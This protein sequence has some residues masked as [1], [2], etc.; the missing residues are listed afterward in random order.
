[1]EEDEWGGVAG[2]AVEGAVD[3]DARRRPFFA[4]TR[5]PE[6]IELRERSGWVPDERVDV[7]A[8]VADMAGRVQHSL[9]LAQLS[10]R[11]PQGNG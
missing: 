8:R 4:G 11:P 10:S 6:D 9:G 2:G 7:S 1:M 3:E 5:K